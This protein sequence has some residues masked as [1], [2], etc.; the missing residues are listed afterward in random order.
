[1]DR[2]TKGIFL[3]VGFCIVAPIMDALAKATPHEIPV[4]EILAAR[5]G[6]QAILLLPIAVLIGQAHRPS[7]QEA[8]FHL[9]RGAMLIIATFCFFTAIRYMP[10]ANAMAIFFVEPFILTFLGAFFLGEVIGKRRVIACVVGFIGAMFVI[11]PSF[12]TLGG[13]ALYPLGTAFTFAIYMIMTRSM[14]Q[15]QHPVALQAYTGTAASLLLFPLLWLFDG[16]G[17]DLFDPVLPRGIAVWTL[18]GVGLI[19]GVSHLLLSTALRLT[20]AGTIAPLQYLEIAFSVAIGY[21]AFNDFPDGWTWLGIAI[22]VSSGIYVF[23]R[24]RA[25]NIATPP[26]PPA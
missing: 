22:V 2:A 23:A 15:K 21:L 5:F 1:M 26:T 17:S 13:V 11:K 20:P 18:L 9:L 10:I 7:L 19:A 25:A 12:S 6:V 24:E 16:S 4:A 14:A 8:G 3:M